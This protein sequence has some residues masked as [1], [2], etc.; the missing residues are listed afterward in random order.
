MNS[1]KRRTRLLPC[2]GT[3]RCRPI[4]KTRSISTTSAL[5]NRTRTTILYELDGDRKGPV[6]WGLL[7]E[8]DDVFSETALSAVRTFVR[9]TVRD[10][11]FSLLVLAHSD[12]D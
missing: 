2:K 5:S 3:R 7:G 1:W 10:A 11:G 9:R 4:P 6:D 12:L 8:V